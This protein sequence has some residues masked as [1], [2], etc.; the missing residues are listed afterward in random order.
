MSQKANPTLIGTFVLLALAIAIGTVIVLGSINLQKAPFRCVA[1]FTGSLYGLDPGAAVTF[2]GVTVGHVTRVQINY[3]KTDDTY[4]IPV[5]I[6][7]TPG[8]DITGNQSRKLSPEKI[9]TVLVQTIKQG[10]KAQLKISS[11]LTGKLY[12]DLDLYPDKPT[13]LH[14]ENSSLV[15]IPT[16]PSGLE[17]I[18]QKLEQLPL[19]EI[20]NKVATALDGINNIVNSNTTRN[21]L[22][23]LDDS[24]QRLNTLLGRINDAVPPVAS[25]L[26]Q[27][28]QK[29]G[30]LADSADHLVHSTDKDLPKLKGQ[31]NELLA[32]LNKTAQTLNQTMGNVRRLTDKNSPTLYQAEASLHA[33]EQAADAVREI[34]DFL[35]QNPNALVFGTNK[36]KP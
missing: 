27:R 6:E 8:A 21:A 5:E 7:L 19:S 32:E 22:S 29:I 1:Y 10:L 35:Q 3:H 34:A 16:L 17:R 15:E 13:I 23:N 30:H 2:R 28:L 4:L 9:K 11:L 31:V 36:D 24:L 12:I 20:L 26:Q 33:I 25:D 14:G 18:T